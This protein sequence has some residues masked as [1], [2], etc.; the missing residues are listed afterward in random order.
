MK[1]LKYKPAQKLAFAFLIPLAL[2]GCSEQEAE[3]QTEIV[4][5]VKT[6]VVGLS[7]D[8][9]TIRK[10]PGV[11][12]ANQKVEL[13]FRVPGKLQ[14]LPVREGDL[15]DKNQVIATLD[16]TDFKIALS[17]R[18]ASDDRNGRE[19]SGSV[20]AGGVALEIAEDHAR[21]RDGLQSPA[22]DPGETRIAQRA[23][24]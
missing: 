20:M 12:D 19:E 5:P 1:N 11:V 4:R 3:V 9:A 15:V 22:G 17:D 24:L 16:P 10:F 14:S 23:V 8:Y 21:R 18:L 2:L 7:G 13:S 6:I